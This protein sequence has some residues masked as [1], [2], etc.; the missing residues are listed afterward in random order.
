MSNATC[1]DKEN[2][3]VPI[4]TM[5]AAYQ[6]KKGQT[7]TDRCWRLHDGKTAP[8]WTF[9]DENDPALGI[10]LL[11]TNGDWCD[12]FG[13]NREFKLQFKCKNEVKLTP[14]YIT[15]I[16]EPVDEG[17]SYEFVMETYKGCPTECIVDN[18]DLCSGHGVC[19]YDWVHAAP[20]CFCYNGWYGAACSDDEDP[21]TEVIY[22]DSDNSYVGALVVV[23][24]L[25]LVILFIL[26]YLFLRYTRIKNQPFDF[27]FL[28]QT[29]KKRAR[30]AKSGQDEYSDE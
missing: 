4:D 17:C 8:I 22:Q 6:A 23:I 27:K 12:A 10:Q 11:Y 3:I 24:L 30:S 25:L 19:D 28:Q 9:L 2:N 5:T 26:G 29:K 7:Y 16:Y 13:K 14:E 1:P 21:N 15:T 20:K 18:E